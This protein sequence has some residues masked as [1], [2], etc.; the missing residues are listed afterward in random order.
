[1]NR[2][3]LVGVLFGDQP[4]VLLA[5]EVVTTRRI[6]EEADDDN[7][8]IRH[9]R[10][11]VGYG[12]RRYVVR[13][14]FA[15]GASIGEA[16]TTLVCFEIAY[17]GVDPDHR[18]RGWARDLMAGVA[19]EAAK[20]ELTLYLTARADTPECRAFFEHFDFESPALTPDDFYVLALTDEPWPHGRIVAR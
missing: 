7:P 9:V 11:V 5:D 12:P 3:E 8:F 15:P 16:A 6:I 18:G 1:V 2:D 13:R 10:A 17:I 14:E 19:E 4:D 20:H